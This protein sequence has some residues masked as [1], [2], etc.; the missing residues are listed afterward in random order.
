MSYDTPYLQLQEYNTV[1]GIM[2]DVCYAIR[3]GA[4]SQGSI[5][6]YR[7]VI[8]IVKI[9][10]TR[11][12]ESDFIG[13]RFSSFMGKIKPVF[14]DEAWKEILEDTKDILLRYPID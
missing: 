4:V 2:R 11:N 7:S 6:L 13:N 9:Y 10:L 8:T 3:D 14:E 12:I 1:N 5:W